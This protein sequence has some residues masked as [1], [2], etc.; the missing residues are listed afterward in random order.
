MRILLC[1]DEKE[2][3][4]AISAILKH[5]NYTVDAVY[6]GMDALDYA[7]SGQYDVILLDIMM[8]K[9]NGLEV[10]EQLRAMH[11]Q[12]PV[13]VLSAKSE[14]EDRITGLDMGADD[15]LPKPFSMA[16]MLARIRALT[17]RKHEVMENTLTF[18]DLTLDRLTYELVVENKRLRLSNREFQMM[19]MLMSHPSVVISTETFMDRIWGYDSDA[20]IN[21]VWVYISALRKKLNQLGAHVRIKAARGVGYTL[22]K[23]D[24]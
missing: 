5:H 13:M 16:E 14:I 21:V 10:L 4:N 19:E 11:I 6:D 7:L 24:D 22:E 9:M 2:L 8:P 12:T 23:K 18:A 1:E 15:Y 3:S 17:R 20:E